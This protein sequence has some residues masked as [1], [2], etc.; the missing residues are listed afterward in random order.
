MAEAEGFALAFCK[1]IFPIS[2]LSFAKVFGQPLKTATPGCFC[3]LWASL[4]FESL[5]QTNLKEK[6]RT[7]SVRLFLLWRRLRDSNPR[8][9]APKRFSRP[10]RY[11]RFDKPP[12]T[13]LR[14]AAFI[15]LFVLFFFQIGIFYEFDVRLSEKFQ[16][17]LVRITVFINNPFYSRIDYHSR[18]DN[19]RLVRDVHRSAF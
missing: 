8:G 7:A 14:F 9:L 10:P 3:A 15:F 2:Y 1:A 16:G 5:F 11:D 18:T 6:K 4:S 12:F 17:K 13:R 19:A